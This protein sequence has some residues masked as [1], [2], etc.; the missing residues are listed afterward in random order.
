MLESIVS[1]ENTI[2]NMK[3]VMQSMKSSLKDLKALKPW[4]PVKAGRS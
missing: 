1:K 4:R 3:K 2:Y